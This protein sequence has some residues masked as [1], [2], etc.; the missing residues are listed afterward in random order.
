MPVRVTWLGMVLVLCLMCHRSLLQAFPD[1][2]MAV[3]WLTFLPTVVVPMVVLTLWRLG[4]LPPERVLMAPD[5]AGDP[6][7]RR[8]DPEAEQAEHLS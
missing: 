7:L 6:R 4:L 3:K 1:W 5:E 2:S 8:S